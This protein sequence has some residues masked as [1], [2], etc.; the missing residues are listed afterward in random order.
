MSERWKWLGLAG[1][2]AGLVGLL[3]IPQCAQAQET[4][5]PTASHTPTATQTATQ[6]PT[7]THTATKTHTPTQTHTPTVTPTKTATGAPEKAS[8]V[9]ALELTMLDTNSNLP[10]HADQ[11]IAESYDPKMPDTCRCVM[12]IVYAAGTKHLRVRCPDGVVATIASW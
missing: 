5:T 9:H 7:I 8:H 2:A 12:Y 6:T 1:L 11:C 3:F 4:A 10:D